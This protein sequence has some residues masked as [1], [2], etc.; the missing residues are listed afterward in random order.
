MTELRL[1][2]REFLRGLAMLGVVGAL[3]ACATGRIAGED[4]PE[5]RA[6]IETYVPSRLPGIAAAVGRGTEDADYLFDGTIAVDSRTAVDAD[7]LWRIYSMTKP[8]TGMAAMILIDD[9]TIRLDQNIADF[10]SGFANP[11]VLTDPDASLASR[12]AKGPITV[13]HLLT[14]TAGLGY[15]IV[16]QGP[17]LKEYL[18]LGLTPAALSRTRLLDDSG[19]ETAPSLEAFAD[20]LATLPLIAD[21]GT[22]WSYS[23]SLDLLGRVIE[24][25]SGKPFDAFLLERMFA[26][27][28]MRSSFWRVPAS[29]VGRFVTNYNVTP[30][31]LQPIDPAAT[32][33]Y[34]DPPPFPFGGAGLVMSA[35]DYDRFLLMLMGEGAI[36]RARIMKPETVRL[37]MSNLLPEGVRMDE[38]FTP[39]TGFGAGGRVTLASVPGGEGAGTFGWSGAAGTI[40]WVDPT[41]R[42]RASGFVQFLP[43]GALPFQDEFG[44]AV[45][46][47]L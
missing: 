38:S 47:G 45:Y 30:E 26:P 4:W 43:F 24:V 6:L 28:G 23:L 12:P 46:A 25:A 20:R 27:L 14:H 5:V 3:P 11:R 2:R 41:R 9:G 17:L 31:G 33:V 40:G 32:S 15:S 16:T 34:L 21:P 10:I 1:E 37:G 22:R 7:T 35:R 44:K 18:R 13:R 19:A 42:V 36:G 8:I 29:E 39:G